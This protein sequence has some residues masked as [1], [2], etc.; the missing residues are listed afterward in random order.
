MTTIQNGDIIA[1]HISPDITGNLNTIENELIYM[2]NQ[3]L[4]SNLEID[5][6]SSIQFHKLKDSIIV[7]NGALTAND[8]EQVDKNILL[9]TNDVIWLSSAKVVGLPNYTYNT[10]YLFNTYEYFEGGGNFIIIGNSSGTVH[11]AINGISETFLTDAN[12]KWNDLHGKHLQFAKSD[13]PNDIIAVIT[14]TASY[15]VDINL[16]TILN[17][18]DVNKGRIYYNLKY[19]TLELE[20]LTLSGEKLVV[21]IS[22]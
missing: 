19:G 5:I 22:A 13:T 2:V 11:T 12:L 17:N 7:G 8:W 15:A 6:N 9:V 14:V 10:Y 4:P 18:S 1:T 16:D 20:K 21:F 3:K